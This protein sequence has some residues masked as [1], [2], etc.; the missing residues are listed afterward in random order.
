MASFPSNKRSRKY[1]TA[2]NNWVE[3]LVSSTT[4]F[5]NLI[6]PSTWVVGDTGSQTGFPAYESD[7]SENSIIEGYGPARIKIP[8]WR[9][10]PAGEGNQDGGFQTDHETYNPAKAYRFTSFVSNKTAA[11]GTAYL[12]LYSNA[13]PDVYDVTDGTGNDSP[14]FIGVTPAS[15]SD[16]WFVMVGYLLNHDYSGTTVR[17]GTYNTLTGSKL[18]VA[19]GMFKSNSSATTTSL[20][21]ILFDA[22]GG[23][24]IDFDKPRIDLIDGTEP[25]LALLLAHTATFTADYTDVIITGEDG[26]ENNMY[27]AQT[28][29]DM[30]DG[31]YWID[32]STGE[33]RVF[34]Y[35]DG[36][37]VELQPYMDSSDALA[38]SGV[39]IE[40]I[41]PTYRSE[42]MSG[43]RQLRS[44]QP[45]RYEATVKYPVA[46]RSEFGPV[47]AFLSYIRNTVAPFYLA[48][49]ITEGQGSG[50]G[51]PLVKGA[52]QTGNTLITD[53]WDVDELGLMLSGD[54][55]TITGSDK[56]YQTAQ[57][58]D[59][60]SSGDSTF[61]ITPQLQ[62]V[63]ADDAAIVIT[64]VEMKVD[65]MD[66]HKFSV[67][68]PMLYTY[69]VDVEEV[70][71]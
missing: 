25:P 38:P 5:S 44:S 24:I 22:T 69:E 26:S 52:S 33:N 51:M 13:I 62:F 30:T 66:N 14:Q 21:S 28:R 64:N 61:L 36:A 37:I 63:P 43:K 11:T 45:Q 23:G 35:T 8:V 48:L 27:V 15:V 68:P 32:Y 20:R 39:K 58:V 54:H 19:N 67:K 49:P 31:D 60:D 53:G 42:A 46:V 50:L 41:D 7:T 34:Y 55:F 1:S 29:P 59:S 9:A 2:K 56:V 57:D 71:E 16:S 12:G 4:K 65:L 10:T 3:D 70:I 40:S 47:D 17:G 6:D 18:G